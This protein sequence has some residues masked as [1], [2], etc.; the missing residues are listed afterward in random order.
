MIPVFTGIVKDGFIT[1]DNTDR[2]IRFV[3]TLEGK[4]IDITFREHKSKRSTNQN[5]YYF[6]VV[7]KILGDYFGYTE[8][9]MH[10]ALKIHFLS[11][12]ACDVPTVGSTAKMNT[13]EFEDYLTKIKRWAASEY[14][15]VIP[16]PNEIEAPE[17]TPNRYPEQ[18]MA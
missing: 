16:D 9:E 2:V 1:Y 12:G 15:V 4:R 18:E 8:D 10:E 17:V 11:K 6:G 7:C 5:N 13:A 3:R 14:G